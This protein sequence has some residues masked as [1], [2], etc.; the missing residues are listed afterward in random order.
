MAGLRLHIRQGGAAIQRQGNMR[1]LRRSCA[2]K[3]SIP[4]RLPPP[5]TTRTIVSAFI[6]SSI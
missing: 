1:A 2:D 3:R 6:A 5:L 4:M